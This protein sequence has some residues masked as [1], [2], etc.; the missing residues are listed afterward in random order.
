VDEYQDLNRAE[1]Q[2]VDLV[3]AG[4][5]LAVVGDEDQSIY[6]FRNAHPEGMQDFRN[7]HPRYA[8]Y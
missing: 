4:A 2:L 6:A 1:Q 8:R 3:A 5:A 7:T